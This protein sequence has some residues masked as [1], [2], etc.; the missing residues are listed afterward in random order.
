M[1]RVARAPSRRGQGG[2]PQT[3]RVEQQVVLDRKLG[4]PGPVVR[5]EAPTSTPA[6]TVANSW[7][8]Y[9]DPQGRFTFQHP[10]DLLPPSRGQ[11]QPN[12]CS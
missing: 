10:Q 7:L 9:T 3:F 1:A 8:T 6:A 5:G 2:E 12:R 11:A 4:G